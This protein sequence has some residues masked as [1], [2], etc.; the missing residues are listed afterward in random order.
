MTTECGSA[1]GAALWLP[2]GL[3]RISRRARRLAFCGLFR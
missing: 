3:F 1:R 2:P